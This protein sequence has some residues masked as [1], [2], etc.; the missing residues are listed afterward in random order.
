MHVLFIEAQLNQRD[1]DGFE[2]PVV[3]HSETD[4]FFLDDMRGIIE[5]FFGFGTVFADTTLFRSI[6]LF[7]IH[8]IIGY[9]KIIEV[10]EEE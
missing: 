8:R 2:W 1:A 9:L 3:H 6:N 10:L 4:E 7:L 5:F